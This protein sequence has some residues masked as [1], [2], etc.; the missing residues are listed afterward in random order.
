MT[1]KLAFVDENDQPIGITGPREDAWAN[2]YYTRNVRVVVRDEKGRVL[3]QKR[4]AGKKTYPNMW[5]VAASGHV[6]DGEDWETAA[7]RETR[8]EI[9]VA[10]DMHLIGS[11]NFIAD[12]GDKKI[13]QILRVYETTIDSSTPL[14]LQEEEVSESK[15]YELDELKPLIAQSP[16][17]FTPSFIEL[18][19][20]F[21]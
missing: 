19:Q 5:T 15:W 3:S 7:Q 20:K 12:E 13:R 14:V 10:A 8:E 1:E 11:F 16:E 6:D 18:I 21:Y 2:G 4:S 17:Q 9:G